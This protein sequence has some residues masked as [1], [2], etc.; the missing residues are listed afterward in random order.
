M[1]K[2]NTKINFIKL[3]KQQKEMGD[4]IEQLLKEDGYNV[5]IVYSNLNINTIERGITVWLYQNKYDYKEIS[6]KYPLENT[7]AKE[8]V[9][10]VIY[11][12]ETKQYHLHKASFEEIFFIE[13]INRYEA[14][15]MSV[16]MGEL[17]AKYS[18]NTI[19]VDCIDKVSID[20][21]TGKAEIVETDGETWIV[22]F[23]NQSITEK[24]AYLKE[25]EV[26]EEFNAYLESLDNT[27]SIDKLIDTEGK[28][29]ED[30]E[31]SIKDLEK[32]MLVEKEEIQNLYKELLDIKGEL[33]ELL[34]K[35]TN[36]DNLQNNLDELNSKSNNF[37]WYIED[38]KLCELDKK[39]KNVGIWGSLKDFK[40][41]FFL[42]DEDTEELTD[43]L[44][45][46]FTNK[47]DTIC[48][49]P[50]EGGSM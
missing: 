26:M 46:E 34:N 32:Y 18:Q 1:V 31:I 5:Q 4:A 39:T 19:Y 25:A 17:H 22:D 36:I 30:D 42:E 28:T 15:E 10:S 11:A 21:E 38:N 6:L 40:N 45:L 33:M 29:L 37:Y 14:K 43:T 7:S 2:T 13:M 47:E 16:F 44:V 41:S 12:L 3:D 8:Y 35:D 50:I 20:F 49:D 27:K 23:C 48:L 9:E 24:Q